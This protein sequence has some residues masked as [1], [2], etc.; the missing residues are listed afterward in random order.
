[1]VAVVWAVV[2]SPV[3]AADDVALQEK[4]V[5]PIV[6]VIG[7]AT[8]FPLQMVTA[9]ALEMLGLGLTV[10]V[11]VC[12]NP[13]QPFAEGVMVY[14]TSWLMVEV[15]TS[16]SLMEEVFCAAVV[17]PVTLLLSAALQLKVE[18]A[19]LAVRGR[20]VTLTVCPLQMVMAFALVTA[21]AGFIVTVTVCG[22]PEQPLN[23]GVTV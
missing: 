15:L 20:P 18:E 17:S 13:V 19:T 11:N 12:G 22:V 16:T 2:L 7:S 23:V 4:V 10:T 9:F 8:L 3:T 14:S 1:M 5:A 21:G 6:E